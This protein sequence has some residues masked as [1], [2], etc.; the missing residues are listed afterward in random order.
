MTSNEL[1][2]LDYPCL[3]TESCSTVEPQYNGMSREQ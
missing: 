1:T 3:Q 2:V